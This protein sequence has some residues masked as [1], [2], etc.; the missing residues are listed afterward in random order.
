[1]EKIKFIFTFLYHSRAAQYL[2]QNINK[3][4]LIDIG[5]S[6]DLFKPI[7]FYQITIRTFNYKDLLI[8]R[9]R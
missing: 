2:T 7:W 9:S 3:L 4:P 5:T 1:M 8:V 6:V